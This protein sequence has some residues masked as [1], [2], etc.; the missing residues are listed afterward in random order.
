L[1]LWKHF[2]HNNIAIDRAVDVLTTEYQ[3]GLG[4]GRHLDGALQ[5][6]IR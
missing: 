2:H 1:I 4:E 6:V 3:Q 5:V